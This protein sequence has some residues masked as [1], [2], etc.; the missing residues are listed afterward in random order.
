MFVKISYL[1]NIFLINF[2]IFVK[3]KSWFIINN[4]VVVL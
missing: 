3:N 2:E 4:Y 1:I